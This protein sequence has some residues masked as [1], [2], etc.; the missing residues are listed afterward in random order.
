MFPLEK[1]TRLRAIKSRS[2]SLSILQLPSASRHQQV[3]RVP[4][5]VCDQAYSSHRGS[6]FRS[7]NLLSS[8]AVIRCHKNPSL[9]VI[10]SKT[11]SPTRVSVV[12]GLAP[13]GPGEVRGGTG[14][15]GDVWHDP[16][17]SPNAISSPR[18]QPTPSAMRA[19]FLSLPDLIPGVVPIPSFSPSL[20]L[21]SRR[22]ISSSSAS[23]PRPKRRKVERVSLPPRIRGDLT[24]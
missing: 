23:R 2:I 18:H 20:A 21:S 19:P 14:N 17:L 6:I 12:A 10:D 4:N 3:L 1:H 8:Y 7:W 22:Q 24:S 13:D 11:H 16:S 9:W 15:E 5:G